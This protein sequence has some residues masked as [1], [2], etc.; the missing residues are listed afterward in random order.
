MWEQVPLGSCSSPLLLQGS[1]C[2]PPAEPPGSEL[3]SA[4]LE[5]KRLMDRHMHAR[6][7][8]TYRPGLAG[9]VDGEFKG[10][11][12]PPAFRARFR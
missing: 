6:G 4:Q 5:R 10:E 1:E 3:S 8:P 11:P 9:E 2:S 7:Q 12:L